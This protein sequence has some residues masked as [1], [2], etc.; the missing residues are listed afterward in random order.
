V[1]SLITCSYFRSINKEYLSTLEIYFYWSIDSR[2]CCTFWCKHHNPRTNSSEL[3]VRQILCNFS[4]NTLYIFHLT[5]PMSLHHLVK[6]G[7]ST[8]LPNTGMDL[9]QSDCSDLVSKWRGHAVARQ[10]SCSEAT[11]Y[12]TCAG[13]QADILCFN[14]TA[15]R[16]ISTRHHR[17]PGARERCEKRVVI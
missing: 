14:R 2:L 12:Q 9:L 10:L 15:P 3:I 13:C 4:W 5:Q 1:T 16:H 8:F 7:C 11:A 6:A 17:F